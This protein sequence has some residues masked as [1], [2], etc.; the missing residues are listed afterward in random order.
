MTGP[1]ALRNSINHYAVHGLDRVAAGLAGSSP[2]VEQSEN[3]KQEVVLLPNHWVYPFNW[4]AGEA[5]RAICSVEQQSFNSKRCQEVLKVG[6]RE[7]ISITYWSHTHRGK[8][9]DEKNLEIVSHDDKTD[10]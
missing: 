6:D 7:S 1:I 3:T 8:G 10:Y 4:Y 2:F 9:T 5:L